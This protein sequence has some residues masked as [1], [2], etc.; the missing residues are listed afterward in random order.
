MTTFSMRLA[1]TYLLLIFVASCGGDG[2][3]ARIETRFTFSTTPY[4]NP[5]QAGVRRALESKGV[6]V[7]AMLCGYESISSNSVDGRE[8]FIEATID[9][10]DLAKALAAGPFSEVTAESEAA[11]GLRFDCGT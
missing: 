8:T 11:R 10:S 5:V 9:K 3:T 4:V 2:G 7:I 1:A 6:M